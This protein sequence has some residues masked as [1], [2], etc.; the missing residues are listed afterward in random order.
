MFW[1]ELRS[2]PP[3]GSPRALAPDIGSLEPN[4]ALAAAGSLTFGAGDGDDIFDAPAFIAPPPKLD[5]A[6]S[7][8]PF[9][10]V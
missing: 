1:I 6:P 5:I 9:C 3:D 7:V 10:S 2:P 8:C 4:V